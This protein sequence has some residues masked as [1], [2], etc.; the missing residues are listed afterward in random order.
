M[1]GPRVSLFLLG[2]RVGPDKIC[3]Q[4]YPSGEGQR[5]RASA[6]SSAHNRGLSRRSGLM[7]KTKTLSLKDKSEIATSWIGVIF[8]VVGGCIAIGT[9][10][11]AIRT[12]VTDQEKESIAFFRL[13]TKKI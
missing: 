12:Q 10:V 8:V 13:I 11:A 7:D 5:E 3:Y 6:L 2:R 1:S 4:E 9:Y